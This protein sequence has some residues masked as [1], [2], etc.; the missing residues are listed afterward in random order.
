MLRDSVQPPVQRRFKSGDNVFLPSF[1]YKAK[2]NPRPFRRVLCMLSV[3]ENRPR[4]RLTTVRRANA[5]I[6]DNFIMQTKLEI[7]VGRSGCDGGLRP[8]SSRSSSS[9]IRGRS[10]SKLRRVSVWVT[11]GREES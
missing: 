6:W 4:R 5:R 9:H 3:G 8:D 7:C 1:S 10:A 11:G 2:E